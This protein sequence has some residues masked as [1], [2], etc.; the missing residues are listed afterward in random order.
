[1]LIILK[2]A[3]ICIAKGL[4]SIAEGMSTFSIYPN[5]D[6]EAIAKDL[7]NKYRHPNYHPISKGCCKQDRDALASD[8][9]AVARD[10][11]GVM[12]PEEPRTAKTGKCK[13]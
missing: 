4:K 3:V 7:G 1:M 2:A 11:G 6:Y 5:T 10:L 8:W 12:T 9:Q 13:P